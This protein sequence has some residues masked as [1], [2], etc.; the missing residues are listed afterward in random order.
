MRKREFVL[1]VKRCPICGARDTFR[2]NGIID[3]IPY[4][5]ELMMT[6]ANCTSCKF[7]HADVMCLGER[8]PLRYE[9]QIASEEDLKVR[10]VKSSTGTME[11]PELGVTVQPGPASQGYVSNVEGVLDRVEEAIKLAIKKVDVTKRRRG[12]AKLK[13][14][15]EAR[16][17]KRRVK[18][19]FM[20]PF[21]HSAIVDER[22]KKR[23][24]TKRELASLGRAGSTSAA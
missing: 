5:D 24:L 8:P 23:R 17:G 22:A 12:Q 13:K 11:L 10:V 20:D 15:G 16:A 2:V 19:I 9:F 21:G 1:P 18:L 4:L 3:E 14:L 7:R 6:S